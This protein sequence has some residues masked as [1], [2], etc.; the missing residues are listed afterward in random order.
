MPK[1][2]ADAVIVRMVDENPR[3]AWPAARRV[4]LKT[5][6]RRLPVSAMS[7]NQKQSVAVQ[8]AMA[9]TIASSLSRS[10][11]DKRIVSN[12]RAITR[13]YPPRIASVMLLKKPSCSHTGKSWPRASSGS[14]Q[15]P[16]L[17]AKCPQQ[18]GSTSNQV[19]G[20]TRFSSA[21][22]AFAGRAWAPFKRDPTDRHSR[23]KATAILVYAAKK[24]GISC[25]LAAPIT[26]VTRMGE[27]AW[28]G[29]RVTTCICDVFAA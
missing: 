25:C 5:P 22:F 6:A 1:K 16:H 7:D 8:N 2:T 10:S 21:S 19:N 23:Q 17:A 28:A 4:K 11:L 29:Y 3:P 24:S 18:E 20:G 15:Q 12:R 13:A 14:L 26:V 9:K 27:S